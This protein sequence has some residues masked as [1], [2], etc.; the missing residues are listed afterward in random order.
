MVAL[1]SAHYCDGMV[2]WRQGLV[3]AVLVAAASGQDSRVDSVRIEGLLWHISARPVGDG[4][5]RVEIRES[6]TDEPW[7]GNGN[8]VVL[9]AELVVADSSR[10]ATPAVPL[11]PIRTI[12]LPTLL[13]HPRPRRLQQPPIHR[14]PL[15]PP[16]RQ[17]PPHR[18]HLPQFNL[19]H[20][21]P[22]FASPT[23]K[24]F[25]H[26]IHNPPIPRKRQFILRLQ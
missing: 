7:L 11:R 22:S 18:L 19:R 17:D 2:E 16:N 8:H 20:Q 10:T 9:S 3:V 14:R 15:I 26:R 4:Q 21:R 23:D 25:P 12:P 24:Y 6:T 1:L 5:V 13:L